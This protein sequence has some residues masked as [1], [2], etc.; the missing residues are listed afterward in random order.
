[1]ITPLVARW[2]A[3]APESR[4]L[5][6]SRTP[7]VGKRSSNRAFP[8]MSASRCFRTVHASSVA[9]RARSP[10]RGPSVASSQTSSTDSLAVE[11]AAGWIGVMTVEQILER[12]S[13]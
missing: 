8:R 9:L 2:Q 13:D 6:T 12:A 3:D 10:P 11:L 1:M 7:S 5:L 4:W